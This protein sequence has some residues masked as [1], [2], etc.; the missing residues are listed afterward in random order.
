MLPS[1]GAIAPAVSRL[2]NALTTE[3]SNQNLGFVDRYLL[4]LQTHPVAGLGFE[5]RVLWGLSK[6]GPYTHERTRVQKWMR[7]NFEQMRGSLLWSVA[8]MFLAQTIGYCFSEFST[9]QEGTEFRLDTLLSLDPRYYRFAGSSGQITHLEYQHP[10][11]ARVQIPYEK[12]V[13]LVNQPYLT[14]GRDPYGVAQCQRIVAAWEAWKILVAEMVVCGQ[15]QATPIIVAK[16]P[17][18]EY[19]VLVDQ[20]G[21]PQ[22]DPTTGE[23]MR[24]PLTDQITQQLEGLD[25]RSVLVTDIRNEISALQ[26]MTGASAGNFFFEGLRYLERI[27]LL[28]EGVP[29]TVLST[30]ITGTGDS[31][32][33][34]GHMALM[35]LTIGATMQQIKEGLLE[36]VCRPLIEWKFGSQE[37]YGSFDLPDAAQEDTIALLSAIQSITEG[38]LLSNEDLDVVNR[39][40]LL[41]GLPPLAEL[42]QRLAPQQP[43]ESSKQPL[44]EG[45]GL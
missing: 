41:A 16:V 8:E 6:L 38:K 42:I 44:P 31:G 36:R 5:V 34:Q 40:R 22:R 43:Q 27:M 7:A 32:L 20:F 37:S 18:S 28:G 13:H 2:V 15:R 11:K 35:D 12:G 4:M 14:L 45:E 23:E 25:N 30:G 19:I 24:I 39:A 10:T 3:I 29:E 33:N 9:R 17:T 21:Q 26:Q 1:P